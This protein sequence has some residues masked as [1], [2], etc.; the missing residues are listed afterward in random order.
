MKGNFF[1]QIKWDSMVQI[2]Q[3]FFVN[4][5]GVSFVNIGGFYFGFILR[6]ME[7]FNIITEWVSFAKLARIPWV[8]IVEIKNQCLLRV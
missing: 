5:D 6:N 7:F 3:N 1:L 4:I 2:Q 8:E